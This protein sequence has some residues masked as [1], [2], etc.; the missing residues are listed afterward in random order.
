MQKNR[1]H[2][3][4]MRSWIHFF[5]R[6]GCCHLSF[7]R[8]SDAVAFTDP[9]AGF[10]SCGPAWVHRHCPRKIIIRMF[11]Y[12]YHLVLDYRMFWLYLS[13]CLIDCTHKRIQN[14]PFYS[15]LVAS[16]DHWYTENYRIG[17]ARATRACTSRY[18]HQIKRYMRSRSVW[19][20]WGKERKKKNG[21]TVNSPIFSDDWLVWCVL[22]IQSTAHLLWKLVEL[23]V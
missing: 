9:E 14:K 17:S 5:F 16:T 12:P 20:K 7:V 8:N 15:Y 4:R 11:G 2:G 23:R 21:W 19:V 6:D 13:L 10:A 3:R 18:R 22:E 1:V